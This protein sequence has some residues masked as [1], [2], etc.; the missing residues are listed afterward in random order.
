MA[1][2]EVFDYERMVM[3]AQ[4]LMGL[5]EGPSN[6]GTMSDMERED[7]KRQIAELL[8]GMTALLEANKK[9][10]A[11]LAEAKASLEKANKQ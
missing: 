10:G 1:E 2:K 11:D 6:T 5:E 4:Y 3:R 8:Q 7:Y 9:M